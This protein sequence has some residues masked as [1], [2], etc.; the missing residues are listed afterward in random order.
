MDATGNWYYLDADSQVGPLTR[1]DLTSRLAAGT[2]GPAVLVWAQGM[3]G[4]QQAQA[5][6]GRAPAVSIP[7]DALSSRARWSL[8]LGLVSV[9][10][11]FIPLML[12]A[13]VAGLVLG[14]R[15][16]SSSKR[17]MAIAGIAL[18]C[19]GLL[20]EVGLGYMIFEMWRNGGLAEF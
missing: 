8:I 16:L 11:L 5:V 12:P 2:L 15:S 13:G 9:F 19:I 10:G 4:W 17:G 7:E 14:I 18:S 3:D 20:I 6:F 1:A